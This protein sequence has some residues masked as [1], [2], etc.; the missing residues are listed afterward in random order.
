MA[1][2]YLP[3]PAGYPGKQA[4][5][6]LLAEF[7]RQMPF[8]QPFAKGYSLPGQVMP[9]SHAAPVQYLQA[10]HLHA[11]QPL[12]FSPSPG[13]VLAPALGLSQPLLLQAPMVGLQP[14]P[15]P[16][17]EAPPPLCALDLKPWL[18]AARAF[19]MN[20]DFEVPGACGRRLDLPSLMTLMKQHSAGKRT[21]QALADKLMLHRLLENLSVPQLPTLLT[22][23]GQVQRH[24]VESFVLTHLCSPHASDIVA[25][26][27][28]QSN[29]TGVLMLSRPQ[30]QEV[31]S[32]IQYIMAHARQHM[33][34]KAGAHE[35]LALQSLRPGFIAQPKYQSVVGFK[36]PLELRV[37]A[38][39]GKA[40]VAV[41]WW[42]RN[43]A[44]G[45]NPGRNA[46]LVRCPVQRGEIRDDDRWELMHRHTGHNP[47]FEKALVLFRRHIS[48]MAATAEHIATAFGAPFLRADFFVGSPK[49]GVRLNEVAYGCGCDYRSV[50]D[51]GR[52]VDDGPMIAQILQEG[53]SHCRRRLPPEYFLSKLGVHG[54]TYFDMI[55]A[56][57][58]PPLR[59][60]L[61]PRALP[62]E[63]DPSSCLAFA[64]P[65]DLCTTHRDL[66]SPGVRSFRSRTFDALSPGGHM[67]LPQ[68]AFAV[69]CRSFSFVV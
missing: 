12:A 66:Q 32:C 40:R 50:T 28:H 3:T 16:L 45:E 68:N 34:Q 54:R 22:L 30:P 20:S 44:P 29:A 11:V 17:Q 41:W 8:Q 26:P 62:D 61:S 48:A 64:V 27:T 33:A 13:P 37:V 46:W 10:M 52:L 38:L 15:M 24:E 19:E 18:E 42:G 43:V 67:A 31:G 60:R 47:G 1:L 49:W 6:G 25:K 35:S 55:V 57:L 4:P 5:Q 51:D 65:E 14:Q 21:I 9:V 58:P 53:M 23:E 59:L 63:N 69:D 36:S 2:Q 56:P 39:W 7:Q